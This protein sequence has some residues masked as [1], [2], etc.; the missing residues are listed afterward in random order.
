MNH[1]E[2]VKEYLRSLQENITFALENCDGEKKFQRDIWEKPAGGSGHTYILSDGAV[3]EQAGI[4]FSHV[5]GNQ[6]PP[7]AT[8]KNPQLAGCGFQA[9]GMSLVFHPKNPYVPTTHANLR[10]FIAE[11]RGE[12]PVWWFGGGYDL[13]PY[14]GFVEDCRHWHQT[15]KTACD[16]FGETVYPRFKKACDD[17]FYLPHR[18]EP[19]GIGG[20]F[21]DDLKEWGFDGTFDFLQQIGDSFLP[22]YLP[23]VHKRKNQSYGQHEI[24]FQRYRRGRYVEFN[25]IYDRGTLFGLQFGGRAESILMSLPPRVDW[26]Y[27]WSPQPGSGEAALYEEF[28]IA[29]NWI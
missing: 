1:L 8:A 15:A 16:A 9:V 18:Q 13:T 29:K 22:A 2:R 3:F 4:G 11:K 7:A 20:L 26:R 23:I 10:F 6:L 21:F 25:L 17:Y 24:D 27:N 19:R 12:P 28:L 14:Y 5:Y